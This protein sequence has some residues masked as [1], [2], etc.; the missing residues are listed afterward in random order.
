MNGSSAVDTRRGRPL[1]PSGVGLRQSR[2]VNCFFPKQYDALT[3]ALIDTVR[4]LYGE[5]ALHAT[6]ARITTS[7]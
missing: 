1:G 7:R 4:D 3:I 2:R 5:T 6:L